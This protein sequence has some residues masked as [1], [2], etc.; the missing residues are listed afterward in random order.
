[1]K[2]P[3]RGPG[4]SSLITEV[5]KEDDRIL[6]RAS[7]PE[8]RRLLER[9]N[10]ECWNWEQCGYHAGQTPLSHRQLWALVK[11]SRAQDRRE[12]A[13]RDRRGKP[14]SYRLPPS[15][16]RVLHLIDR[17]LGGSLES[18]FPQIDSAPDRQRYLVN[19]L[20]EEAIASSQIE[21]AAVTREVAKEMLRTGREPRDRDERMILNNYRT[22]QMLNGRRDEALS[23]PLLHEIQG[24]LTE[25]ALDRPDAAG[26]FRLPDETVSV[27]DEEE[28][29]ALHVPPPAAELPGR[30]QQLCDFVNEHE[31]AGDASEFIH[32]AVR[33]IVAHFWLAYDHPYV[34]G[35]GRTA[36]ALFYWSMLRSGYWLVEYLT[37]SSIIRNQPK[38]Y[39]RA[40]LNTEVDDND[41]TYFILYHLEV[42]ERSIR[43]FTEY[44]E[45]KVRERKQ[46]AQVMRAGLFNQRQQAILIKAQQDPDT[47]FTYESHARA[48]GVTLATARS[49]LLGLEAKGLVR[50]NRAGR[51]FEFVA[52]ADLE[53]R[54]RRLARGK[55]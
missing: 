2:L 51:R 45:D 24:M 6:L 54:L 1:M 44:L 17:N 46:H 34:D 19:S 55:R 35:N 48:H 3:K 18:S 38:Q 52:A 50:G 28:Q 36:R 20:V 40:F 32:P 47:R 30:I 10:D 16:Q 22:I 13:L 49:D 29:Q 7:E 53:E 25:R 9:A 8:I 31:R 21:G 15:A 41:L 43:A 33:A 37:I 12:L 5:L 39:A 42:I 14:F 26:R 4:F 23:V 11:L 27:W